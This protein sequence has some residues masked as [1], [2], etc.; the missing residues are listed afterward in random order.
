MAKCKSCGKNSLFTTKFHNF[1]LCK[2]CG[3]LVNVS[4]WKN[5]DF[6]TI[7]ELLQKKEEIIQKATTNNMSAEFIA[8]ISNYFDEYINDGF[9]L[10]INGKAGQLLKIFK[11]Y[12]V[13]FTK[14]ETKKTELTNSFYHFDDN[15]NEEEDDIDDESLLTPND[16]KNLVKGLISGKIVQTGIN[17]ALSA[18]VNKNE[19]ERTRKEKEKIAERKEEERERKA[20][21]LVSVGEKRIEFKNIKDI[22]VFSKPNIAN[23]YLKFVPINVSSTNLYKCHYFFFNNSIPFGSRKI[24]KKIEYAN[25]IIYKLIEENKTAQKQEKAKKEKTEARKN[26]GAAFDEIREFKKLLDEGIISEEE[27]NNKKKEL[28]NL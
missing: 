5:R 7:D 9:V 21:R 28:L 14:N 17:V 18:A 22:E 11:N 2:N 23:G 15:Y 26:N 3:S 12:C 20:E 1:V 16:K 8:D 19:K 10:S 4:S 24:K 6:E 13:V 27:F 25:N